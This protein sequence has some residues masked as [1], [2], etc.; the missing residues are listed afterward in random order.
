MNN[1]ENKDIIYINN[2]DDNDNIDNYILVYN[3]KASQYDLVH[4]PECYICMLNE[5]EEP[6]KKLVV[7][8][9]KCNNLYY[10]KECLDMF[11]KENNIN[12]CTICNTHFKK[13]VIKKKKARYSL[14]ELCYLCGI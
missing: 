3:T 1:I 5:D 6:N 4:Q 12:Y 7:G 2:I 13:K 9:C 14:C 11:I 10:H 8:T